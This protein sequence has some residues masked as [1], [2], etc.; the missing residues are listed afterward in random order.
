MRTGPF[1]FLRETSLTGRPIQQLVR[2][3]FF[4]NINPFN[5]RKFVNNLCM[6]VPL[7]SAF[8][9]Q[10][11]S[12]LSISSALAYIRAFIPGVPVFQCDFRIST[13]WFLPFLSDKLSCCSRREVYP[14]TLPWYKMVHF[15]I[16]QCKQRRCLVNISLFCATLS[17]LDVQCTPLLQISRRRLSI[18]PSRL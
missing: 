5:I 6:T 12:W 4:D 8:T 2:A 15:T 9:P 3:D 16:S 17:S 13:D 1:Y 14:P 7:K 10:R 11:R 18:H